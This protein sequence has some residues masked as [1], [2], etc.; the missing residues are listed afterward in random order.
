ML[1]DKICRICGDLKNRSEFYPKSDA[2]DGLRST[3]KSC[4][5]EESKKWGKQ[6]KNRSYK[7]HKNYRESNPEKIKE[8]QRNTKYKL[9]YGITTADFEKL[10]SSQGEKCEICKKSTD[11]ISTNMCVDH[12]HDTGKVR[13]ILCRKC[14]SALGLFTDNEEILENAISYL[15]KH[16]Q[17]PSSEGFFS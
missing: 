2:K 5:S 9:N 13:G 16:K 6:N 14:N 12:D 7:I 15:K 8:I 1:Q 10:Y 3:C 4:N 11:K 17:E